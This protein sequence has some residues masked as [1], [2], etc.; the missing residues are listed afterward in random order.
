[1]LLKRKREENISK[2]QS[3]GVAYLLHTHMNFLQ[4]VLQTLLHRVE[5]LNI[6]FS[7]Q[8]S[9]ESG[10]KFRPC[11]QSKRNQFSI[12]LKSHQCKTKELQLIFHRCPS[13]CAD[14]IAIVNQIESHFCHVAVDLLKFHSRDKA[15]ADQQT[16]PEM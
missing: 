4:I 7:N 2:G 15:H 14:F 16:R 13:L 6:E 8:F 9:L 5:L 1:M 12:I 10:K 3:D 11:L